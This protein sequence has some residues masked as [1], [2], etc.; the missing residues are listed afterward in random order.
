MVLVRERRAEERHDAVA[1]HLVDRAFVAVD[2]LHHALEDGVEQPASLLGI[3][4][5]EELHRALEIREE[6]GDL[7]ALADHRGARG[8]DLVGEVRRRVGL[9]Y[10]GGCRRREAGAAAVTESGAVRVVLLAGRT[11]HPLTLPAV[12]PS[13]I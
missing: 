11:L 12:S 10:G 5:G 3:A 9:G 2:R 13:T 4:V 8:Q 7:L 1:H 6:D